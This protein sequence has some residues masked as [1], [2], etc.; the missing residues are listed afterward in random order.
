VALVL[1]LIET[2]GDGWRRAWLRERGLDSDLLSRKEAAD[3]L[4][5]AA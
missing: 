4:S 1:K 3:A 2:E 5:F